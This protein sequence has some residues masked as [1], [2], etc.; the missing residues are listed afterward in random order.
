M[1]G[2]GV[3]RQ[4]SKRQGNP[5]I[6]SPWAT[7]LLPAAYA[8]TDSVQCVLLPPRPCCTNH[9][10]MKIVQVHCVHSSS[11]ISCVLHIGLALWLD[12]SCLLS[13]KS[14]C[15]KLHL[16]RKSCFIY[17]SNARAMIR[18]KRIY[19]FRCSML[20][21]IPFAYCFVTLRGTFMHFSELTY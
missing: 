8:S 11:M 2:D 9:S 21:F 14:N 15:L 12:K 5:W 3:A 7:L 16:S 19:N 13:S 6:R 20:V 1:R 18:L 10:S 17:S 4:W